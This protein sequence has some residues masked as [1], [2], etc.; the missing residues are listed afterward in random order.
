[1][2][3]G[4]HSLLIIL[5]W[6]VGVFLYRVFPQIDYKHYVQISWNHQIGLLVL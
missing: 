4:T 1:M 5:G 3:F 6:N 2:S